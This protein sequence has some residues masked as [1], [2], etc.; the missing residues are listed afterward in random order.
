MKSTTAAKILLLPSLVASFQ[1]APQRQTSTLPTILYS[2]ANSAD[3]EEEPTEEP[4]LVLEGL[5]QQLGQLKSSY[6]TSEIDYLAAARKRAEER[7]ESVNSMAKDEDWQ[8]MADEKKNQFGEMDDWE[9]SQKEAGNSDSQIL[10]FTDPAPGEG[11]DGEEDE[12][13]LLLF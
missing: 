2:E 5:D 12:P 6:P 11:E 10:M 4:G 13:K 9:S 3:Q 8:K 1:V 7:R